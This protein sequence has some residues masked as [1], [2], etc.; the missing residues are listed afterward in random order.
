MTGTTVDIDDCERFFV[1]WFGYLYASDDEARRW[2]RHGADVERGRSTPSGAAPGLDLLVRPGRD[3][4]NADRQATLAAPRA[5]H[6]GVEVEHDRQIA[7]LRDEPG[8]HFP[9]LDR[10]DIALKKLRLVLE[11]SPQPAPIRFRAGEAWQ[12][13]RR[14]RGHLA[15]LVVAAPIIAL[16]LLVAKL[17]SWGAL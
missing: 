7:L 8:T 9:R 13:L 16:A 11:H 12:A 2:F 1:R 5:D 4:G 3:A 14:A 15:F 10:R 17:F 6:I